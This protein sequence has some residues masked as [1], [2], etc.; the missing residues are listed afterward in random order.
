MITPTVLSIDKDAI[1]NTRFGNYPHSTLLDKQWGSQVLASKLLQD[2]QKHPRNKNPKKRKR[3]ERDVGDRDGD[4]NKVADGQAEEEDEG[5]VILGAAASGFAH[6]LPPTPELWTQSL[7]HRTQV[8][9]T[10][11]YS[12]V[13]QRLQVRPGSVVIEAGAGSGSFT[14]AASRAV[15]NGYPPAAQ[16]DLDVGRIKAIGGSKKPKKFGRVYSYEYHEQRATA[17]RNELALHGLDR[18]VTVT[19]RDV[20]E[21]GFN[22]QATNHD[23]HVDVESPKA[24]AIFLDLP[25]P[26]LALMHLTR[27]P[28]PASTSSTGAATPAAQDGANTAATTPP[29]PFVSPLSSNH[30]VHICTFSPCIEQVQRTVS[31][32]RDLGWTDID[33]VE[34]GARRIDV[35]RERVGLA[36][37][38]SRDGNP[39]PAT[40][41]EAVERLRVTKAAE[42]NTRAR[43]KDAETNG[44]IK[45]GEKKNER[46]GTPKERRL[47]EM[48]TEREKRKT[49]KEGRIVCRNEGE[50][51]GHTS[52][53]VFAVLPVQ[54]GADEEQLARKKLERMVEKSKAQDKSD[55]STKG[56]GVVQVGENA[57][58]ANERGNEAR[59]ADVMDE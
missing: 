2:T 8:V 19:Y 30:A 33:M 39:S 44:H 32:L 49:W 9:Y 14:H 24:T 51:K 25:A 36:E 23:R 45:R 38:G 15:F 5:L 3:G 11:D 54:W 18:I 10:P 47:A 31:T 4:E 57:V 29:Y 27:S 35:R 46:K 6:I 56:A 13:L 21:Y 43:L 22:F 1:C 42:E 12:Y 26:W 52:Y 28:P 34:L 58:N 20:Y 17:L 37:E 59:D 16:T 55:N 53:L 50:L 40:V 48:N 7:P 41:E